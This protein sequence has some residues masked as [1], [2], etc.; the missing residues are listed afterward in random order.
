MRGKSRD[1]TVCAG[2]PGTTTQHDDTTAQRTSGAPLLNFPSEPVAPSSWYLHWWKVFV[3][4][5]WPRCFESIQKPWRDKMESKTECQW[6]HWAKQPKLRWGTA[7]SRMSL[8]GWTGWLWN[9]FSNSWHVILYSY[10]TS[11]GCFQVPSVCGGKLGPT[12]NNNPTL[13]HSLWP[14]LALQKPQLLAKF[15]F[16]SQELSRR[17]HE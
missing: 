6:W 5:V 10:L 11:P 4:W 9:K 13:C 16:Y 1:Q 17:L 7:L 14:Q 15:L 3:L 12:K 8:W 2:T